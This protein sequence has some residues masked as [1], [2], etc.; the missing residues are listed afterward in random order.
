MCGAALNDSRIG[1]ATSPRSC[2]S[3]PSFTF[4]GADGGEADALDDKAFVGIRR[5]D[6][7]FAGL[8]R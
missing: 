2:D 1:F 3:P 7:H 8:I 4:F 5:A 6:F